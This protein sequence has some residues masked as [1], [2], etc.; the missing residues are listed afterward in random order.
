M[1]VQSPLA[2]MGIAGAVLLVIGGGIAGIGFINASNAETAYTNCSLHPP[3]SG[4]EQ[5]SNNETNASIAS[6]LDFGVGL[7]VGGVGSGLLFVA[8][9][10]FMNR[11]AARPPTSPSL[12]VLPPPPPAGP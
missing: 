12:S 4:C 6:E 3:S 8:A 9:I 10:S 5:L 1:T 7:V 11:A 2:L